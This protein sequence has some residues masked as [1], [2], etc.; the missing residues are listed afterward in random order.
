MTQRLREVKTAPRY[1]GKPCSTSSESKACN[2]AA[3]E[4]DCELGEWTKWTA[5]SKDCDGG[6]RKRQRF[7][8]K[9]AEGA[10]K[11]AGEWDPDRLQYQSCNDKRCYSNMKCDRTQDFI[12]L[13]DAC[14][15]TGEAG[16][17]AEVKAAQGFIDSLQGQGVTAK[18]SVAIIHYCGPRTW[19]GVSKCTAKSG[20]K[21]DL[22]KTC[23]IK[24]AHHFSTDLAK[25][26]TVIS[27]LQYIPGEK[28]LSLALLAAKAELS[29][30][31]KA[32]PSNVICFIDGMPLS[33]RQTHQAA[34]A[35]RK[36]AR[37]LFVA[38]TKFAPLKNIKTWATRRWEENVV[39]V[40]TIAKLENPEVVTHVVANLCP[41]ETAKVKFDKSASAP[42]AR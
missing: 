16:W 22:E 14:P 6:T 30:G 13:L 29:L 7:I 39:T 5:C 33:Q 9:A 34:N 10:G 1:D 4:K 28:L 26:K 2:V 17:A 18:P 15:K 27:G 8:A 3:C 32:S 31:D 41:S 36:A 23:K 40:D 21:V 38:V 24:V 20:D 25:A 11:C 19:S 42:T 37:L 12:L 35:I